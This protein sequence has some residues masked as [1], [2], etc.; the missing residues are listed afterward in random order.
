M[1]SFLCA[2]QIGD[3]TQ[4]LP[5]GKGAKLYY[6][7]PATY[8]QQITSTSGLDSLLYIRSDDVPMLA[9]NARALAR[10]I[11]VKLF[12]E[13]TCTVSIQPI[14]DFV[15]AQSATVESFAQP[16]GRMVR[17]VT[18]NLARAGTHLAVL[19][20]V[21]A[22]TGAVGILQVTAA[23]KPLAQAADYAGVP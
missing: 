22:R 16:S 19:V 20:Q 9:E 8:G 7:S 3:P 15:Y 6:L 21:L 18:V 1:S 23:G 12:H 17:D 11:V 5:G 13:G 2:G 4:G 14:V 10:R